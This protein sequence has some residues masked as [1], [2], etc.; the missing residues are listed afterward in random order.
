MNPVMLIVVGLLLMP[1]SAVQASSVGSP[2]TQGRGKIAIAAEGTFTSN[3]EL[4]FQ[5]ATRPAGHETD[6]PK[7][8]EI[9][10]GYGI[11]GKISYGLFDFMDAYVKLGMSGSTVNGDVF[12]GGARTVTENLTAN[13]AFLYGGGVKLAY[14]L[15]KDWIIGG[16]A[17]YSA[18][19]HKLDFKATN[20]ASGAITTAI[21]E[22][23]FIWEWHV[24]P[25]VARRIAD[26]T[27]YAGVE[28]SDLRLVQE[29]PSD[30][31]R[32][33][34]LKFKADHNIGMFVGTAYEAGKN[35]KLNVEGK[36]MDETAMTASVSYTF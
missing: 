5:S 16:D 17:Q 14:G 6:E 2:K 1:L 3:R 31:R 24:A 28:Y 10:D 26:F 22:N 34:H 33:D 13:N 27:P 18:S 4:Q 11:A 23:C 20:T 32:W 21:Y 25:Y 36:F 8:F 35:F 19:D 30:P 9:V 7:N 29:N 15:T 12:V